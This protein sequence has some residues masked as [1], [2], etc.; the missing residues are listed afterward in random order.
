MNQTDQ[1][2][3]SHAV[4]L[5]LFLSLLIFLEIGLQAPAQAQPRVE[6]PVTE[7]DFGQ[8]REDMTL[9]HSFV[10]KNVGDRDLKIVR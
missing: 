8:V 9:T 7:H 3:L 4:G 2:P 10:I 1:K 6:I 5:S